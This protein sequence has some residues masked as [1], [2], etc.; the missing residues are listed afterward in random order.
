MGVYVFMVIPSIYGILASFNILTV[1]NSTTFSKSP[2]NY[3][4]LIKP[5]KSGNINLQMSYNSEQFQS[6]STS[7]VKVFKNK[8]KIYQ[9]CSSRVQKPY[10]FNGSFNYFTIHIFSTGFIINITFTSDQKKKRSQIMDYILHKKNECISNNGFSCRL[11]KRCGNEEN[12]F[13]CNESEIFCLK[14]YDVCDGKSDCSNEFII[15]N[16]D[17]TNCSFSTFKYTAISLTVA[18]LSLIS[19]LTLVKH[20]N[21]LKLNNMTRFK[22]DV[23]KRKDLARLRKNKECL[24]NY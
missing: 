8:K 23:Y 20:S 15:D 11:N 5:R 24:Y 21:S 14:S 18:L 2:D 9:S 3:I 16:T 12:F 19:I 6:C 4:I 7:L 10:F 22:Q 1:E 13:L 17:E